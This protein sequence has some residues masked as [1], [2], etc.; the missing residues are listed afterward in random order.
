[1]RLGLH[2]LARE[3]LD[4]L[5]SRSNH[6]LSRMVTFKMRALIEWTNVFPV[7]LR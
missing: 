3:R 2:S 1:M 7:A 4:L 6:F 5:H